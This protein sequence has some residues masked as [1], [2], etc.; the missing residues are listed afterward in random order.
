[1]DEK[2]QKLVERKN[3][4]ELTVTFVEKRYKEK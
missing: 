4:G 1:M 3:G 2:E